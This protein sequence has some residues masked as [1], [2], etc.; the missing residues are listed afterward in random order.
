MH[1]RTVQRNLSVARA[2]GGTSSVRAKVGVAK[3]TFERG[4][5]SR[6]CTSCK[7]QLVLV[8]GSLLSQGTTRLQAT[9][10]CLQATSLPA[11]ALVGSPA[12]EASVPS[13]ETHGM[14]EA[15]GDLPKGKRA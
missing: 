7:V 8:Q 9:S 12:Q 1:L 11:A 13:Q 6:H 15:D 14:Q 5:S 3:V 10:S 4:S 2:A